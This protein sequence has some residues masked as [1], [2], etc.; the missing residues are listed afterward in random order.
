M[1]DT[2]LDLEICE[3][4][5]KFQISWRTHSGGL[6]KRTENRDIRKYDEYIAG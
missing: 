4:K 5:S 6:L 1:P 3:E 2:I